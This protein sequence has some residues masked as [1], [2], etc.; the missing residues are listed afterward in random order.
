MRSQGCDE[1]LMSYRSGL[2][3]NHGVLSNDPT[4][5]RPKSPGFTVPH[6]LPL[7][8]QLHRPSSVSSLLQ[9]HW[10]AHWDCG[11]CNQP[12]EWSIVPG[13]TLRG[14]SPIPGVQIQAWWGQ[15]W[16]P[17]A[18]LYSLGTFLSEWPTSLGQSVATCPVHSAWPGEEVIRGLIWA[19]ITGSTLEQFTI[20]MDCR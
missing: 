7:S 19:E 8:S 10:T 18:G 14:E 12:R 2:L 15:V 4:G 6:H 20:P 17:L 11:L 9:A 13:N 1:T 16:L 5:E 3:V